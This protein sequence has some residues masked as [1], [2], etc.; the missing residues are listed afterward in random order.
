MG[1]L[2]A[3]KQNPVMSGVLNQFYEAH[4][5]AKDEET[6]YLDSRRTY[7]EQLD[8]TKSLLINEMKE[9]GIGYVEVPPPESDPDGKPAII[10]VKEE[11]VYGALSL[12]SVATALFGTE[13]EREDPDTDITARW[14][15]RLE[16]AMETLREKRETEKEQE[17]KLKEKKAKQMQ[18]R[19]R[20][21]AAIMKIKEEEKKLSKSSKK[22][23]TR[24]V[25]IDMAAIE[26]ATADEPAELK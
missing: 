20:D 25:H 17:A 8:T 24:G 2:P 6:V 7:K 13:E 12:N 26:A 9:K 16:T 18:K 11:T 3:Q 10:R 15:G 22:A 14:K 1:S 23:K 21:A 4:K 5:K 19:R